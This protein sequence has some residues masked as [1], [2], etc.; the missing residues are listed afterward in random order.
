MIICYRDDIGLVTDEVD[1]TNTAGVAFDGEYAYF[2]DTNGNDR[3]VST[4]NIVMIGQ[5]V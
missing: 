5:E 3:K 2:T 4:R 1:M